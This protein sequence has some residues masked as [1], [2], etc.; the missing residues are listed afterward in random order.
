MHRPRRSNT[1][2]A[3]KPEDQE[4]MKA[5]PQRVVEQQDDVDFANEEP[6][7]DPR[8]LSARMGV[9]LAYVMQGWISAAILLKEVNPHRSSIWQLTDYR[10]F[11]SSIIDWLAFAHFQKF[12][13]LSVIAYCSIGQPVMELRALVIVGSLCF[14]ELT[15]A[16]YVLGHISQWTGISMGLLWLLIGASSVYA[17]GS[18]APA[19]F[20]F[21]TPE[22]VRARQGFLSPPTLAMTIEAFLLSLRVGQMLFPPQISSRCD[23]NSTCPYRYSILAMDYSHP[24]AQ[25]IG[26]YAIQLHMFSACLLGVSIVWASTSMKRSILVAQCI[27][28][29]G[30]MFLHQGNVAELTGSSAALVIALLGAVF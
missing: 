3:S 20:I 23:N 27:A 8:F 5:L 13:L 1:A 11:D 25:S 19:A 29:A 22:E 15:T 10:S 28:W 18:A 30:W 16:P 6:R 17:S 14:A 2:V 4:K 21:P 7:R 9:V 26:Q 24:T 12:I